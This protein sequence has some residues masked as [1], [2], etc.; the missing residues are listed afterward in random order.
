LSDVTKAPRVN[1]ALAHEEMN[2][3][4]YAAGH[5]RRHSTNKNRNVTIRLTLH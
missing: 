5:T 3:T 4:D 1:L 2:N